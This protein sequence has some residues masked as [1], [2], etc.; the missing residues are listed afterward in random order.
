MTNILNV[1]CIRL[2]HLYDLAGKN[3]A[4]LNVLFIMHASSSGKSM[5]R[6]GGFITFG[7][8]YAVR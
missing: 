5:K 1:Y 7:T 4:E 6:F 2:R 3:Y 8:Y